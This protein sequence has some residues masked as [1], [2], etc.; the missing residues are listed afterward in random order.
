MKICGV[1]RLKGLPRITL[2]VRGYRGIHLQD[3][4]TPDPVFSR[5]A[6][7]CDIQTVATWM[8]NGFPEK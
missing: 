3:P 1:K 2:A 8:L 5:T 4:M 7:A 6:I